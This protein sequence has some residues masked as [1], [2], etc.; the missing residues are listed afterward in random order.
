[1]ATQDRPAAAFGEAGRE[2][3][4]RHAISISMTQVLGLLYSNVVFGEYPFPT[5]QGFRLTKVGHL[6]KV[7]PEPLDAQ[8]ERR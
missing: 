5:P 1:M 8:F 6:A 4:K 3:K 7:H 2:T